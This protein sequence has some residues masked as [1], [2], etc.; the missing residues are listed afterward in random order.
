MTPRALSHSP[1]FIK[2]LGAFYMVWQTA[3]L[4]CD[5]AIAEFLD[6]PDEETHL[7]TAG[8]EFGRKFRFLGGLVKRSDHPR[9]SEII[10]VLNSLQNKSKRNAFA[11]SYIIESTDSRVHFLERNAGGVYKPKTHSYTI[12]EFE[13]HVSMFINYVKELR[14]LLAVSE[15]AVVGFALAAFSAAQSPTMSP[16]PPNDK[17]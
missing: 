6:I 13:Q 1:K 7:L 17:A 5:Y 16:K 14:S 2:A 4:L 11:H 9:K 15:S 10:G 3:E 12:N 8:L